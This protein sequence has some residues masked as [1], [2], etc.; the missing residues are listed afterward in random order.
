MSYTPYVIHTLYTIY[1]T[2]YCF[3]SLII[4]IITKP[5]KIFNFK[6]QTQ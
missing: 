5:K 2:Q 1:L 4:I 6:M 3:L